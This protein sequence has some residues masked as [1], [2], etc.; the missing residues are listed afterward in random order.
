LGQI[1]DYKLYLF[2][3]G[4]TDASTG[5]VCKDLSGKSLDTSTKSETLKFSK[6]FLQVSTTYVFTLKVTSMNKSEGATSVKI[7]VA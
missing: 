7:T 4:C 5:E 2:T 6:E 3:W 1:S